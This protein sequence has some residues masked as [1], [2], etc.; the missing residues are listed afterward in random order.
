MSS[1]SIP[2]ERIERKIY[3]IRGRKVMLDRDLAALYG[4][5]TK[6]LNQAVK[7]NLRRFPS[8]FM[9]RLTQ[10]EKEKVVTFCDHLKVLKFSPQL[11]NAFTQEGIAMLSSVLNSDRAIDVNIAIMRT[12]VKLREVLAAHKELAQKFR[13]L[14]HRV[15]RHDEK[16]QDIF[17]AIR[18]LM[19]PPEKPKGRIGFYKE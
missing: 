19:S 6:V 15:G 11:P 8:D 16:I 17:E 10:A 9:F 1:V 4:V 7:R 5:E 2:H 3:F 14:E 13:E 18:Q 12:F